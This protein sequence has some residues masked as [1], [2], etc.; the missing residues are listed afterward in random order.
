MVVR[1]KFSALKQSRWHE[2]AIRFLLGG[3]ATVVAGVVADL[4]G[5]A[6]GGLFLAVPAIFCASATLIEKHERGRKEK[7]GLRGKERG[8]NAAALDST[9]AGLGSVALAAF[10]AVMWLL[11]EETVTGSLAFATMVWL[12]VATLLWWMRRHTRIVGT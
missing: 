3:L 10:G 4:W 2:Y 1:F 8:K 7:K 9:G 5:P 6:V 11:A 12:A